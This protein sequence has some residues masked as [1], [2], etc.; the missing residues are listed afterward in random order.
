[1]SNIARFEK[2]PLQSAKGA[3]RN[4]THFFVKLKHQEEY[5]P[6]DR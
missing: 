5:D 3:T 6:R 1:M 4:L 2:T